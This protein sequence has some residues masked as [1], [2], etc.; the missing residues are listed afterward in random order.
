M[1]KVSTNP[2]LTV[3]HN[4]G[5]LYDSINLRKSFRFKKKSTK[6]CYSYGKLFSENNFAVLIILISRWQSLLSRCQITRGYVTAKHLVSQNTHQSGLCPFSFV[7]AK[8]K[9][10]KK[11]FSCE[12]AAD[13]TVLRAAKV[14][15]IT[16][17]N[18][19]EKSKNMNANR[20]RLKRS[21][22]K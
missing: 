21:R 18:G 5:F 6:I 16:K 12:S 13:P 22:L 2:K 9:E 8:T 4:F 1:F 17:T 7:K 11:A 3:L 15:F 20:I 19:Y 10:R 14:L